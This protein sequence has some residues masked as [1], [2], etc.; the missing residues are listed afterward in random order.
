MK[1]FYLFFCLIIVCYATG[2]II[3]FPDPN[4]KAKLLQP[5][6]GYDENWTS[7]TIDENNNG[8]IEVSEAQNIYALDVSNGAIS[9][10]TGISYFK[11]LKSLNCNQN[12]LTSLIIDTSIILNSLEANHNFLSSSTISFTMNAI[13]YGSFDLSYNNLTSF[14]ADGIYYSDIF[15][16]SHNQLANLAFNNCQFYYFNINHNNLT[17]VQ[18]TG[19]TTIYSN[20]NFSNNQFSLLDFKGI[21]FGR[22]CTLYLGNNSIDNVVFDDDN[23]NPQPPFTYQPGNIV[24][25]SNNTFFDLGNFNRI[26]DCDPENTGHL[27]V[28]NCP[29]LNYFI[30]KN[31][32][33][34]T[35]ITCNEGGDIFQNPAL[36]LWI[37]NCPSLSFIC[38]D[39]LEKPYIESTISRW[40]LQ[41]Q[42]VVNSNCSSTVLGRETFAVEEQFTISPVPAHTT[43]QITT[44]STLLIDGVEIFNNLGQI[45]LKE[46]GDNRNIDVS[47]LSIGSYF[48]K[49]E[50]K[51]SFSIKR[52][53]KQ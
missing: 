26:T 46:N 3:N 27:T 45:V 53:L 11:E 4:F 1:H 52:F 31:G 34:H 25:S 28:E 22:E 21:R 37:D 10:L 50:T 24:Y 49:I 8:E 13:V 7:K 9:D 20:S 17:S 12:L 47:K 41:S 33:N 48:I 43:L 40:G 39:E 29:N 42:V 14:S 2:Q 23:S 35:Y 36:G 38:V 32:F 15:D 44:N 51:E 19:N 6:V 16:L 30:L 5:N 18:F